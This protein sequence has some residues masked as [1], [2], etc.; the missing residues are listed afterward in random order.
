M[1]QDY[2]KL[3]T[4]TYTIPAQIKLLI[5]IIKMDN[6]SLLKLAPILQIQGIHRSRNI[7]QYEVKTGLSPV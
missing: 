2:T 3:K 4:N 7:I 5:Y 6:N 1:K